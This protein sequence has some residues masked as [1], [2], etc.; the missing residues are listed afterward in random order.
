MNIETIKNRKSVRTYEEKPIASDKKEALENDIANIENPF[1]VPVALK[2]LDGKQDHL[3]S[4]VIVGAD[5]WLGGKV[6]LVTDADLAFGYAFEK[7]V[8]YAT[9][10]GLGTVWLAATLDRPA[11]EKAMAVT[12]NE[13]MPAVSPVGYAAEKRSVRESLMRKGLKADK[14]LKFTELFFQDDFNH[15]LSEKE[16]GKWEVPLTCV[17]WAPSATNTQPW[18]LVISDDGKNVHFYEKHKGKDKLPID[19]HKVDLGIALC[20]FEIAAKEKGLDGQFVKSDPNLSHAAD[21]DYII[22]YQMAE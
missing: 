11:F 4:P 20:H 22:S 18:R 13:V 2:L 10:L 16:A 3:S 6:A 5:T 7:A 1:N 9:D 19:I 12:E 17:R 8:L 15:A 21:V 14:R